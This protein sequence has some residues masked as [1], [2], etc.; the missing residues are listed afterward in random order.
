MASKTKKSH[1]CAIYTRLLS[2]YIGFTATRN[3]KSER[4]EEQKMKL[5]RSI[6]LKRLGAI[7]MAGAMT[8]TTLSGCGQQASPAPSASL[9]GSSSSEPPASVEVQELTMELLDEQEL[10]EIQA[11]IDPQF[12]YDLIYECSQVGND[13]NELGFRNAG[14]TGEKKARDIIEQAMKEIGLQDVTVEPF[15]VDAWEFTSAHL[16]AED[17]T[18]IV[19]SAV[20]GSVGTDGDLSTELVDLGGGTLADYE[21]KDVKGKV[22]LVEFDNIAEY[23]Y[24]APQYEAELQ[25]AAAIL[26]AINSES[27]NITEEGMLCFDGCVRTTIPCLSISRKDADYLRQLLAE[28]KD[29]IVLNADMTVTKGQSANIIGYIEG[30]DPDHLIT[31]GAHYDGWY[32]SFQDDLYG[33]GMELAI[34][35]AILESGYQPEYSIAFIAFGAEEY[36]VADTVFDDWCVG[37]WANMTTNHPEW[38]G[39]T[40]AHLEIDSVRPDADTY[41][42]NATPEMNTFFAAYADT[43]STEDLPEQMK[44]NGIA[45]CDWAGPWSQDYSF[46]RSGIPGISSRQSKTLWK[47]SKYHTQFDDATAWN[48]ELF[49]FHANEYAKWLYTLQ[50]AALVPLDFTNITTMLTEGLDTSAVAGTEAEADYIAAIEHLAEVSAPYYAA[51]QQVNTLYTQILAQNL[52]ADQTADLKE[53]LNEALSDLLAAYRII[54]DDFVGMDQFQ[55]VAFRDQYASAN[56]RGLQDTLEALKA[57]DGAAALDALIW[58]DTTYLTCFSKEVYEYVGITG[59]NEAQF[60]A[61][62]KTNTMLNTYDTWYAIQDKVDRGESDFTDEIAMVEALLDQEAGIIEEILV[63]GADQL[64]RAADLLSCEALEQIIQLEQTLLG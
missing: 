48:E 6:M 52:P 34:A 24:S 12:A 30:K 25:G 53:Q 46:T 18:D 23:W 36:G 49:C 17:G 13:G 20:A 16:V 29:D 10:S 2:A 5:N 26:C 44:E 40:L 32:H 64:N 58:V 21:G 54:E 56:Y 3:T 14:S 37:T 27:N 57:G 63:S 41:C 43:L 47:Q 19:L 45:L 60:W 55:T 50:H 4:Q 15:D 51:L 9:P 31:M 8:L 11:L 35:K 59:I 22:A 42:I 38:S 61:A 28:G 62:G 33:V 39:K 1:F 7:L